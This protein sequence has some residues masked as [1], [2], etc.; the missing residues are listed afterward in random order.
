[1]VLCCC[2]STNKM[3]DIEVEEYD[4]SFEVVSNPNTNTGALV[5]SLTQYPCDN[6]HFRIM[7]T[8]QSC[9]RFCSGSKIYRLISILSN[10]DKKIKNCVM[11]LYFWVW[12]KV[13]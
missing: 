6:Y 5:C 1:M 3:K 12:T 8:F 13:P 7:I 11:L 2:C 10:L 4:E 9:I